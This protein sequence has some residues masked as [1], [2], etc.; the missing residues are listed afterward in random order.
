MNADAVVEGVRAVAAEVEEARPRGRPAAR[1]R[2]RLHGRRR[3][4]RR[5]RGGGHRAAPRLPRPAPRPQHAGRGPRRRPGLDGR[6]PHARRRRRRRAPGRRRSAAPA[7]RRQRTWSSSAP[8]RSSAQRPSATRSPPGDLRPIGVDR[9]AGRSRRRPPAK[10]S[11]RATAG[12]RRFL[13]HFDV[14]VI[15]FSDVPLSENTG[16]GIGVGFDAALAALGVLVAHEALLGLTVTELNPHHGAPDGVGRRAPGGRAG[17]RAAPRVTQLT[18]RLWRV[19]ASG[20]TMGAFTE[21]KQGYALDADVDRTRLVDQAKIIDRISERYLRE[22]G[23]VAGM[24][25]LDLGSGMGDVALL[26]GRLVGPERPRP[27]RRALAR[28]ARGRAGAP[29]RPRRD[30]RRARRRRCHRGWQSSAGARSTR[31][32]GGSS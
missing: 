10:R 3:D 2:R 32:S 31:S 17:G 13:V 1:A 12:G 14:D 4:R 27:R 7:A 29:R 19:R 11:E 24:R 9:V 23:I 6:G 25:V 16:R 15:D 22:A 5:R 21:R 26:A 8:D 30:Q 18:G 20:W 28:A